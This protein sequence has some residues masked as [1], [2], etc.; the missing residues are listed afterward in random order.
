M[1]IG[2]QARDAGFVIKPF[3]VIDLPDV[4]QVGKLIVFLHD[5][6]MCDRFIACHSSFNRFLEYDSM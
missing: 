5:A 4:T 3:G 1:Y 2:H 6:F